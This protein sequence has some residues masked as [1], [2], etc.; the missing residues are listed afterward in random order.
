MITRSGADRLE[1]PAD[2]V[3]EAAAVTRFQTIEEELCH[4]VDSFSGYDSTS[5]YH[6]TLLSSA[7]SC[8][9][10]DGSAEAYI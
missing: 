1:S 6:P 3:A 4:F 10:K 8:V 5:I 2:V 7:E 9:L